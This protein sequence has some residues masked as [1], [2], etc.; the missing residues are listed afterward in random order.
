MTI[1]NYPRMEGVRTHRW[2]Y[3]RYFDRA[4][5]GHYSEMI[6]ASIEGELP[7]YEGLFD[8]N[9]D[10]AEIRNLIAAPEHAEIAQSLRQKNAELVKRFRGEGELDTYVTWR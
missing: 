7:I 2:K 6:N 8:L 5:D 4:N 3:V 10:P 9:N 1:Q